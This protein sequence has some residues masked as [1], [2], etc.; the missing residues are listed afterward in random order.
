[1]PSFSISSSITCLNVIF[2]FASLLP[3]LFLLNAA[4]FMINYGLECFAFLGIAHIYDSA[5][6]LFEYKLALVIL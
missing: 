6:Q 1:M 5:H 4:V 3:T 2:V